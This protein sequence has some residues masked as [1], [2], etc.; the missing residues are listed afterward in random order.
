VF[1]NVS[2]TASTGNTKPGPNVNPSAGLVAPP[3][4]FTLLFA[5]AGCLQ[6]PLSGIVF[7]LNGA[8]RDQ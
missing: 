4:G 6:V 3:C 1:V 7:L 2:V 8:A 5:A